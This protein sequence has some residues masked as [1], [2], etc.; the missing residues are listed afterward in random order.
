MVKVLDTPGSVADPRYA[1][2]KLRMQN[3]VPLTEDMA[4]IFC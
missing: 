1:N 4:K 3:R 2:D